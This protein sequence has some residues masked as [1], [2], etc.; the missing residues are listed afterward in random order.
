MKVV[1]MLI[2][3]AMKIIVNMM[4]ILMVIITLISFTFNMFLILLYKI[5]QS[6]TLNKIEK[7]CIYDPGHF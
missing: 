6:N 3:D 4:I 5:K 7:V 2:M 1:M